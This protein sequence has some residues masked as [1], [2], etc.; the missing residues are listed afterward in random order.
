M[1]LYCIAV[2]HKTPPRNTQFYTSSLLSAVLRLLFPCSTE[3]TVSVSASSMC[4]LLTCPCFM[5]V[6]KQVLT[7]RQATGHRKKLL[8]LGNKLLHSS[9]WVLR[10]PAV[11]IHVNR[12]RAYGQ[13]RKDRLGKQCGFS[14]GWLSKINQ[15]ISGG[16]WIYASFGRTFNLKETLCSKFTSKVGF[17]IYIQGW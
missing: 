8:S 13:K 16:I 1:E 7:L 10:W 17:R 11:R 5:F 15:F 9:S 2:G 12:E 4:S 3:T 14:E 6:F